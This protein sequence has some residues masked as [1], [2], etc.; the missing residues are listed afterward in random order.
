MRALLL[1]D[2]DKL[3]DSAGYQY[4]LANVLEQVLS[5]TAQEYQKKMADAFREGTLKNLKK[6]QTVSLKLLQR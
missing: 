1:K 5:N 4:D 3:K 2:Y 6:C